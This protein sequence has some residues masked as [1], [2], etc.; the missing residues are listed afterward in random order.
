MFLNNTHLAQQFF[1]TDIHNII[2]ELEYSLLT[3]EVRG[4][5]E[6]L[7]VLLADDFIEF[8]SSGNRYT[9][10]D[11][12]ERLPSTVNHPVYKVTDF[13]VQTPS[14]DVAIATFTTEKIVEGEAA[15]ISKRTSHW[16]K[17]EHGWQMFFHEGVRIE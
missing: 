7:D 11:I 14:E 13:A 15:V 10:A 2:K 1:M 4:S 5:R 8:G 12:L 9:K 6:M 16:R 17:T 3:P